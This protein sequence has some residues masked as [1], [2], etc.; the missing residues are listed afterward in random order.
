MFNKVTPE[1]VQRLKEICGEAFVLSDMDSLTAYGHDY[2]EDLQFNPEVVVKPISPEEISAIMRLCNDNQVPVTPR[3][4][5]YRAK[6][7]RIAGSGWCNPEHRTDE[8]HTG[9]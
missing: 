9:Y 3:G 1:L 2:T 8:P 4:A 6:R 5:G 7:S